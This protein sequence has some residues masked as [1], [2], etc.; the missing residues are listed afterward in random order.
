M[1]N[2]CVIGILELGFKQKDKRFAHC[3]ILIVYFWVF[4]VY[5]NY[6]R[7]KPKR[8]NAV[9]ISEASYASY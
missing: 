1:T 7:P 9:W 6:N 4:I 3:D 8:R 2:C 5:L